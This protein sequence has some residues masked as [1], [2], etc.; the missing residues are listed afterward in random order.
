MPVNDIPA[1]QRINNGLTRQLRSSVKVF[2]GFLIAILLFFIQ[3]LSGG[4]FSS[5]A[6]I[7]ET[8]RFEN[9]LLDMIFL[10]DGCKLVEARSNRKPYS[11]VLKVFAGEAISQS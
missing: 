4:N 10:L 11:G 1:L 6:P 8:W 3:S 2:G 5:D 9:F 7:A